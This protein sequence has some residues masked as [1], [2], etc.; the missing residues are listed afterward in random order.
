ML[1]AKAAGDF[2]LK[3]MLMYHSEN[4]RDLKNYAKSTLSVLYKWNN[5]AWIIAYLFATWFTEYFNLPVKTDR[6]GKK[7]SF[8]NI[9]AP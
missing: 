5:T 9:T 7:D 6:S 3:S 8:Q 1:G 4:P 2:R